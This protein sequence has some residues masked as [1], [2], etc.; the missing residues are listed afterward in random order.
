MCIRDSI[1]VDECGAIQKQAGCKLLTVPTFDGKLNTGLIQNHMHGF[2]EQHLS[3][4]HILAQAL[5]EAAEAG[6]QLIDKTP[7][8]GAEGLQIGFLHPKSTNRVLT[9]LCGK[10]CIRDSRYPGQKR[11]FCL[12][13]VR[14]LPNYWLDLP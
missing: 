2:G 5:N 3:L 1:N 13:P 6:C 11:L 7:R 10:M 12:L 14:I 4:I 9:E 8:A